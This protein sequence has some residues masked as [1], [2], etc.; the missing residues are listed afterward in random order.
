MFHAGHINILE[1]A[2]EYGDYII[3]GVHNDS[4]INSRRGT[5]RSTAERYPLCFYSV[6]LSNIQA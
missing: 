4:V 6:P 1:T 3:V 2:R 5:D